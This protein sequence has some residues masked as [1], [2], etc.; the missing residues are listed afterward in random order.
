[1]Y[2][3]VV[4]TE[5]DLPVMLVAAKEFISFYGMEWDAPSV[6]T[7]LTYLVNEG[8]VFLAKKENVV[9]GGIGGQLVK[10]PWNQKQVLLQ[11]MFWW[12]DKEHRGS[13][14]GLRLLH[15]FEKSNSV[16]VVL[17]VLPQTPIKQN[18]LSKLGYS[19]KEYS[20]VKEQ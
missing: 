9:V 8:V 14:A 3:I 15:A 4:A 1:M 6:N 2:N 10:N 18:M 5:D 19:V 16:P 17:S 7:M 13:S 12:V 11:E 20:L